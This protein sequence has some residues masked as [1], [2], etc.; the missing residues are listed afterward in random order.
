MKI[1][2]MAIGVL[3]IAAGVTVAAVVTVAPWRHTLHRAAPG[4]SH[5]VA[6]SVRGPKS[7]DLYSAKLDSTL[8]DISRHLSQVSSDH[9]VQDLH[10]IHPA[11]RFS[12]SA[13]T[14]EPLVLIDAV[15]LGDPLKLRASLEALGLERSSQ[16]KNLVGG[17]LPLSQL[18][19]ATARDEVHSLRASMPRKRTGAVTSQGD[20]AQH[21]DT[22]RSANSLDGTGVTVGILSDSYNCYP[23]YASNNVP[24]GGNAGYANNGFTATAA[25]DIS[26][27]DLPASVNVLEEATCLQYNFPVQLPFGDE[28]RAMMQV[29]H[30]VAPGASLMFYTAENSKADFASGIVALANAGAKII[31][32]DVGY[33]DEPFFQDGAIAQAIDQVRASGVTYFS[34]AGNNGNLAYDNNAPA[35]GAAQAS[36]VN[37]GEQLLIFDQSV[38]GTDTNLPVTIPYL[39]PGEFVVIVVEWDQPYLS[40]SPPT[41]GATSSIDV[42]VANLS[43]STDTVYDGDLNVDA[44]QCSG[45]SG[46]GNDP[47]QLIVVGNPANATG[48]TTATTLNVVVG[49]VSG[50]KPGRIK[51][52]V[53][54]DGAGSTIN[55]YAT[56][57]GTIQGHPS[58]AG[59]AAVGAAFFADTPAC[60]TTPAILELF[61]SAGGDPILFTAA[62]APQTAVI[63][64]KPDFVGPDGGN[65]TFLGFQID[66]SDDT[67]TVA[68]C[69]NNA[70]Y[71]NF[72]GTSAATPHVAGIAAL[73][74]Q[75]DPNLTPAEVIADLAQSALPMQKDIGTPTNPILVAAGPYDAGAGFVQADAAATLVP[76][77]VPAAPTLTLSASSITVG[78][79]STLTWASAN[80]TGCTASGSWTGAEPSNGTMAETP[81]AAGSYT[82]TLLCTNAAGPSPTTS[83]TLTV[84]AVASSGGGHSGGGALDLLSILGLSALGARRLLKRRD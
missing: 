22:V 41:G 17:W 65:N 76:A 34:A 2:I 44:S 51:V 3:G 32:D 64:Q 73:M 47:V 72:L 12:Q 6:Y 56:G 62:G 36:G 27:G 4:T 81:S 1:R 14:G 40:G 20:F 77:I 82:Y 39:I 16:F 83:V 79:S 54:D 60:G 28:G 38:G 48:N 35:F 25:T 55:S 26:T 31:A 33:P 61:S 57:G 21:S 69:K 68:G 15:T 11:A 29:V 75:A 42:C 84:T 9:A 53:E 7:T 59:A 8:A 30:D 49:L 71:P 46:V 18:K 74:L 66:P 45:G 43:T 13:G 10:V 24:A 58:A 80:T 5:L 52:V 23:T 50:T 67:S 19:A 70:S 37:T 78:G 63:R